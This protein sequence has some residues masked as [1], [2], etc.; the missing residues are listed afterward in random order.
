MRRRHQGTLPSSGMLCYVLAPWDPHSHQFQNVASAESPSGP[1]QPR[2]LGPGYCRQPLGLDA[3][4]PSAH[5]AKPRLVP[6][7]SQAVD[8][9]RWLTCPPGS[10]AHL[11]PLCPHCPAHR[12]GCSRALAGH[13]ELDKEKE[14]HRQTPPKLVLGCPLDATFSCKLQ[15]S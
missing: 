1:K 10:P 12:G 9:P 8:L 5:L 13:G 11:C 2:S 3:G 6:L 14:N 15:L 4:K 7:A